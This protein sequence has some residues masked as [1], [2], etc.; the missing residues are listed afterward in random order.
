MVA[1]QDL[2]PDNGCFGC[3]PHNEDGLRLK[4][5]WHGDEAI[6]TF[7][8]APHH[9]AGPP[10]VLNG[11]ILATIID[12]HGVCTAIADAYRREGRD[13]GVAPLLWYATGRL[14]I[15]YL[16]PAP[17]G[18]DVE[19]RATVRE[20]AGRK[21]VIECTAE[22]GGEIVARGVVIA[23]RVPPEWRHGLQAPGGGT[24]R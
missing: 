2:I 10:D 21:S 7:R 15:D 6:S 23:V 20:A 18:R 5:T 24:A 13:V 3:G 17:L 4:S 19:L 11:G 1:F 14:E 8:G 16:R 12:C 9:S 22:V